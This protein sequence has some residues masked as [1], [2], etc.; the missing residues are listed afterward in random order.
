M[1]MILVKFIE[2]KKPLLINPP[3]KYFSMMLSMIYKTL[4]ITYICFKIRLEMR[5]RLG[6]SVIYMRYPLTNT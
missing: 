2:A 4:V 5:Y 1:N 6:F 3:P